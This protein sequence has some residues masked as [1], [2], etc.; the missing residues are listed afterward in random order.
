[1]RTFVVENPTV[2]QGQY[3]GFTLAH[4]IEVMADFETF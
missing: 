1:V 4:F 3:F 2:L